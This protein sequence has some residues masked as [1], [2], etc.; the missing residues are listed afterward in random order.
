MAPEYI[1]LAEQTKGKPYVIAEVDATTSPN[2][3]EL[4]GVEG[5]PTL[6]LVANGFVLDYDGGR[7]AEEMEKWIEATLKNEIVE[8]NEEQVKEKIGSEN[9]LL[10]EG[11]NAEELKVLKTAKLVD[12]LPYYLLAG[13]DKPKVTL[14]LKSSKSFEYTG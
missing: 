7:T 5:Y 4:V 9:F 11:V 10:I 12:E 8:V 2:V 13:G 1:K 3:T 14:Y 6:K